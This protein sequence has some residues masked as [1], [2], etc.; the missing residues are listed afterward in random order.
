MRVK[1]DTCG[2][3]ISKEPCE[4]KRFKHHFCNKKC[5]IEYR[6]KHPNK[7]KGK[8]DMGPQRK[9]RKFAELRK[10]GFI[11]IKKVNGMFEKP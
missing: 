7:N 1:C 3:N 4:V 8:R 2:K 11:D 10:N 9:L 5:Y 6:I